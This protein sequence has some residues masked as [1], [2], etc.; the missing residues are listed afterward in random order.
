MLIS[1][2]AGVATLPC[3]GTASERFF[4]ETF[5]ARHLRR[6]WC[7]SRTDRTQ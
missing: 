6:A 2:D 5:I 3:A 1:L 7:M 4:H